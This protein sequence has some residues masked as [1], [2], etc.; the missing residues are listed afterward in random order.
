MMGY[1][2]DSRQASNDKTRHP[3][4]RRLP[5]RPVAKTCGPTGSHRYSATLFHNEARPGTE[6][7][8]ELS[9]LV[10]APSVLVDVLTATEVRST[11]LP[12]LPIKRT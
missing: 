11:W 2:R 10:I 8:R 5:C 1:L 9:I 4:R 7:K 6:L 12:I 3:L